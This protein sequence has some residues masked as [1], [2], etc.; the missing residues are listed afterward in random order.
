MVA[1]GAEQ[2]STNACACGAEHL[3]VDDHHQRERQVERTDRRE[4]GVREVLI[5]EA[6][7]THVRHLDTTRVYC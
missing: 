3:G 2:L 5:D 7:A 4:H 1:G 6:L